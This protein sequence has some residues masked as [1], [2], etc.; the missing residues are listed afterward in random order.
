MNIDPKLGYLPED[1]GNGCYSN[2]FNPASKAELDAALRF[3]LD[4]APGMTF[5]LAPN[6]VQGPS[7]TAAGGDFLPLN[8]VLKVGDNAMTVDATLVC[9]MF[10]TLWCD[11][12]WTF[13]DGMGAYL[14][15][16]PP[17]FNG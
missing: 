6:P 8:V 13:Y 3:L 11:V 14:Y 16:E 5:E 7:K 10:P 2:R 4:R 15:L 12:A 17:P 1:V 9:R